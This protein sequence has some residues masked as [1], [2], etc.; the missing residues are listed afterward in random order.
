MSL[1]R[2]MIVIIGVFNKNETCNKIRRV[3]EQD[4]QV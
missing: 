1:R 4:F 3:E 2:S